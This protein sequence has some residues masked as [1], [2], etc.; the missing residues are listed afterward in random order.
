MKH[1]RAEQVDELRLTVGEEIELESL[2]AAVVPPHIFLLPFLETPEGIDI[3]G[4]VA[5]DED[6]V[7]GS[8]FHLRATKP[9]E[10]ELVIGFRDLRT[11]ETT[12]S[13]SIRVSVEETGDGV[14]VGSSFGA[15]VEEADTTSDAAAL[16]R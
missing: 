16:E 8:V 1:E 15:T 10:G 5:L 12:H 13:K 2:R 7:H 6:G 14:D 9:V 4:Q 11:H 3:E